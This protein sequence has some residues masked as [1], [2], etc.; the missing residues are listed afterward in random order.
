ME[1]PSLGGLSGMFGGASANGA[2]NSVDSMNSAGGGIPSNVNSD[3]N[4]EKPSN[5][6]GGDVFGIPAGSF[7]AVMG[8][9]GS[10]ISKKGSWQDRLGTLARGM[11]VTQMADIA[12][13]A[14]VASDAKN[15]Q[16]MIDKGL[17]SPADILKATGTAP[18][19]SMFAD[20]NPAQVG[21]TGTVAEFK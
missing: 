21:T 8:G 3:L 6:N 20:R 11:G 12:S 19:M 7:S 14:K 1:W 16:E 9:M 4:A 17:I 10:A 5:P 2:L 15:L 18:Q 13:K